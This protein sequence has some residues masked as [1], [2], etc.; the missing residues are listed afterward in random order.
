M[1]RQVGSERER[2]C[3]PSLL[4]SVLLPL[5]VYYFNTNAIAMYMRAMVHCVGLVMHY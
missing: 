1:Y 3:M 2:Q 4:L 5:L